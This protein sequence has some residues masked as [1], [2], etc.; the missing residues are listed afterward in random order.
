MGMTVGFVNYFFSQ[1]C[2][3]GLADV[4]ARDDSN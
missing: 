2:F 4:A 3:M 1:A